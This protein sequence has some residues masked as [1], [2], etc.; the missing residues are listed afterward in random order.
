[1]EKYLKTD[2]ATLRSMWLNEIDTEAVLG[3]L[4][5]ICSTKRET[6]HRLRGRIERILDAARAKGLRSGENPARWRGHLSAV[7]PPRRPSQQHYA[8]MPYDDVP[9]FMA[10]LKER[11]ALTA[12]CLRFI[13]LTAC[14][15]SEGR[16][17]QWS[18]IDLDAKV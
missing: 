12:L 4:Q 10:Q 18:E 11:E 1:M 16:G 8:A 6:A 9:T 13:I 17:A 5:P 7:L 3:A 14:R 15:S 2:A